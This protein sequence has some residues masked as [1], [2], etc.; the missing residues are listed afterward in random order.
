[1]TFMILGNRAPIP[2]KRYVVYAVRSRAGG[3]DSGFYRDIPNYTWDLVEQEILATRLLQ[4]DARRIAEDL[5]YRGGYLVQLLEA[6]S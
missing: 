4:L 2:E 1:M 6:V 3:C 5:C